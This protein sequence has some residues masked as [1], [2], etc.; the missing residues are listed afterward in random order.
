[1]VQ[2]QNYRKCGVAV[3][4]IDNNWEHAELTCVR[5]CCVDKGSMK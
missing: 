3:I 2:Q 4:G 1:M 5:L